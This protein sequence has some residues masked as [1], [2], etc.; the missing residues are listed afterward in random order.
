MTKDLESWL[1]L[2]EE[3]PIDP[4]L[5]ICDPHHHFRYR[6]DFH[7]LLDDLLSDIDQGD[8]ICKTVFIQCHVWYRETGPEELKPLGE[9]EAVQR[10]AEQCARDKR[11]RIDVAAGI[12]CYAD[13][14]RGSR[15]TTVLEAQLAA[16]PNRLRGIRQ[17]SAWDAFSDIIIPPSPGPGML[18]NPRFREGFACLQRYNLNFDAW[19]FHPQL[20][21]LTDLARAFPDTS[22]VLDHIGGPLGVGPYSGKRQE[23][24]REWKRDIADLATCPNVA[25]KLGGLG[26][27][28]CGFG[29]QE[30]PKP[31]GSEELAEAIAPYYLWCIEKFGAHRCMFESNFP[32]D[33]V[34]Y[35]YTVMWNAFKR[36]S[37]DF[38]QKERVALFH[39]TAAKVYRLSNGA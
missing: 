33:K 23:V 32:V 7:Y 26:M 1:K 30:R 38:S 13:L 25:V 2:T 6:A 35:S 17:V 15:V 9:T 24:F 22:I 36:I 34:S 14:T 10:I 21:E 11:T 4:D 27:P 20:P 19:L 12:V 39:D 3:T 29:W 18:M 5:R 28:I 37:R 8:N 31:L 16:S